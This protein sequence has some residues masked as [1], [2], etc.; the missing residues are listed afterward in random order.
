MSDSGNDADCT[1][2]IGQAAA[3][4]SAWLII[5]KPPGI[6]FFHFDTNRCLSV[7][8]ML[9]TALLSEEA[10]CPSLGIMVRLSPKAGCTA[11]RV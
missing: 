10:V 7:Y 5:P 2:Q 6:R 11:L 1:W 9:S 3:A 8:N 4:N